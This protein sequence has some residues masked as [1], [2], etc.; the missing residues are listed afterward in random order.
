MKPKLPLSKRIE[1]IWDIYISWFF[2][3]PRRQ[4]EHW[5]KIRKKWNF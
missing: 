1:L 4:E 5:E 3:S 2:V